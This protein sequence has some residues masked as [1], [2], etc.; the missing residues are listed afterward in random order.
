M[1]R[2][3]RVF[4]AGH[5]QRKPVLLDWFHETGFMNL[6]LCNKFIQ[7]ICLLIVTQEKSDAL[8]V[9]KNNAALLG[10]DAF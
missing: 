4:K 3:I 1:I 2:S 8:T 9:V 5:T 7:R 6:V 10:S